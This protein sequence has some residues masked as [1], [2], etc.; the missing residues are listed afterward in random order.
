MTTFRS[1][2]AGWTF[3]ASADDN[4]A[5]QNPVTYTK[6][7]A[8]ILL[9][10]CAQCHRP[11]QIG[12]MSLLSYD[13][14]RPW[15][16]A[17]KKSV[18]ERVMPPWFA[19]PQYVHYK[20]EMLLTG[21]QIEAIS[22]WVEQGAPKGE[23]DAEAPPEFRDNE[24]R[25][26][27]P[28]QIFEMTAPFTVGDDVEDLYEHFIIP[29]GLTEDKWVVGTEL[30]PG[31]HDVVHHILVFIAPPEVDIERLKRELSE[32][33]RDKDEE[34][35]QKVKEK[36]ERGS[37][38]GAGLFAKYGPGTN[39]EVWHDG[40]GRLMPKGCN[41]LL[42]LHYH[43]QAGA[44]TAKTDR[45]RLA[46]KYATGPV[47]HPITTAWILNPIF[48]IPA[49]ADNYEAT[50]TFKFIDDGQIYA[51]TPHMHLR[52]KDFRYEAIY[53]DGTTETLLSV[54]KWNFNWQ[55]S[56]I[57]AEPKAIPKGTKIRAVAHWDNS[58]KN[59]NNPDP[60]IEVSWGGPS[61][62]EMMIGF[63]DYTYNTKVKYQ[64]QYGLPEGLNPLGFGGKENEEMR[65]QFQERRERARQE[66]EK[67][68]K[69]RSANAGE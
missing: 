66:R 23:G 39:P 60:K 55:I 31:A 65:K 45:S 2:T 34:L 12:P 41:I 46:V 56:Y 64:G 30:L 21:D 36:S 3:T 26:G 43:K 53:P 44:G 20:D 24:W 59:P 18:A 68:L 69:E 29:S 14:V 57:L 48:Q 16:K 61:T 49:G 9:K 32:D 4:A 5:A 50:S 35:S 25:M 37:G 22:K 63:M 33:S 51:L 28:D 38:M 11:G 13:E 54:P 19:D 6:D 7:I 52:G 47:E 10:N 62:D 58:A 67:K 40:R 17:I 1:S 42:Q 8:P 15:A 27:K